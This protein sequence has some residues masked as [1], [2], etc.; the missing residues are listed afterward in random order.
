MRTPRSFA[1]ACTS[2]RLAQAVHL[3]GDVPGLRSSHERELLQNIGRLAAEED[4][5]TQPRQC[6]SHRRCEADQL[7][8]ETGESGGVAGR[9]SNVAQLDVV[10]HPCTSILI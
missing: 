2:L 3:E 1:R 6:T 10:S 4:E 8:I 9:E 5:V 7:S